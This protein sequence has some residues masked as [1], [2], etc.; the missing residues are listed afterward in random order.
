[1]RRERFVQE[2]VIGVE[3]VEH[4]AVA[5][6]EVGKEP[7][8]FLI[9]RP[10]EPSEGREVTFALFAELVEIVDV[11][12]GAGELLRKAAHAR[13]AEHA[14]SLGGEHVRFMELAACSDRTKF[15]IGR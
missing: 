8:R 2:R 9:H 13:V 5:L 7:N 15:G 6:E 14:M 4:R 11:Q 1:M 12:P 10:A 3:N